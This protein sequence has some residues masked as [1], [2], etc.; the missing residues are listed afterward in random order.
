MDNF[1]PSRVGNFREK[2]YSAEYGTRR[3]RRLFRRNSVVSRNRKLS[4]FRSEPFRGIK[5]RSEFHSEPFRV[6]K[7]RSEFRFEPFRGREKSS[8][9]R[10]EPFCGREKHSK[11]C[12]EPFCI[13]GS[14]RNSVPKHFADENTLGISF[15]RRI[16]WTFQNFL[17]QVQKHWFKPSFEGQILVHIDTKKTS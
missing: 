14:A 3:N 1:I 15:R 7:K 2:N 8:E 4:E 13:R 16:K 5:K 17:I 12:S 6:L 9:F 10:S 11:I